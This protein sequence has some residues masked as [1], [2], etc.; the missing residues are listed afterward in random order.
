MEVFTGGDDEPPG[1]VIHLPVAAKDLA[2]ACR[3]AAALGGSLAFL[4][5]IDTGGTTVSAEDHQNVRH[6]VFCDLLL[7]D[8]SRCP[9]RHRH[10]GPC[11][12]GRDDRNNASA[13]W[14][15]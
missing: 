6:R 3:L 5:T 8:R 2:S 7:P 9:Q 11:G 12:E 4:P 15:S 13:H 14:I 1:F 10:E